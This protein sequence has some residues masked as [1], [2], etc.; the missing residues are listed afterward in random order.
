MALFPLNTPCSGSEATLSSNE[1]FVSKIDQRSKAAEAVWL[2][3][4][5]SSMRHLAVQDPYSS[6]HST[7]SIV[8]AVRAV[9]SQPVSKAITVIARVLSSWHVALV[10]DSTYVSFPRWCYVVDDGRGWERHR[11]DASMWQNNNAWQSRR[12]SINTGTGTSTHIVYGKQNKLTPAVC[13]ARLGEYDTCTFSTLRELP[14]ILHKCDGRGWWGRLLSRLLSRGFVFYVRHMYRT[15]RYSYA[16][17]TL[18]I[19][20]IVGVV[21]TVLRRTGTPY[22]TPYGRVLRH[23]FQSISREYYLLHFFPNSFSLSELYLRALVLSRSFIFCSM[24]IL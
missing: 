10:L 17:M 22:S 13:D 15:V 8:R 21:S 6:V 20:K 4:R 1:L 2:G 23:F 3:G 16:K 5:R 18:F 12:A 11:I 9:T 19:S 24:Y 14:Y 7:S